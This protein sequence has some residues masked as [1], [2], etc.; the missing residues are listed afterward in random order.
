MVAGGRLSIWFFVGL[1]LTIY[2]V[3]IVGAGLYGLVHPP[4]VKLAGVHA[5]LWWGAVLLAGGLTYLY[6]YNPS[7]SKPGPTEP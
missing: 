2:G 6:I 5:D 7:R 3:M 1:L 4:N